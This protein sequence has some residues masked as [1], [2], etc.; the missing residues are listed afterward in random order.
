MDQ[1]L[2]SV[3]KDA[4]CTRGVI[5]EVHTRSM[6]Q[7]TL[8][9]A[10]TCGPSPHSHRP[11]SSPQV[12]KVIQASPKGTK[13]GSFTVEKAD[14]FEYTDPIDGSVASKQG[15]RFVFSGG[16]LTCG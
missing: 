14:D 2:K 13:L 1:V 10:L 6:S 9:P 16:N 4:D 11:L 12:R 15:L 8:H 5:H 3:L 7:S